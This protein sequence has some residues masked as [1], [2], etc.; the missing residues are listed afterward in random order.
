MPKP[1]LF[2]ARAALLAASV[3]FALPAASQEFRSLFDGATLE[4]W[5]KQGHGEWKV[6]DGMLVG[7]QVA[8]DTVFGHLVTD[9]AYTDFTFRYRWK[10]VKG[11]S[12]LYFRSAEGGA[13]GMIGPQVEMDGSYPG[14]IYTTN[15]A[16]WGWIVQPRSQDVAA[17]YRPGD[18]NLVIVTAKGLRVEVMYN[19]TLTAVTTD[20]RLPGSG[21]FGFQVHSRCDCEVHVDDVEVSVPVPAALGRPVR[22]TAERPGRLLFT[23]LGRAEAREAPAIPLLPRFAR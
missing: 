5:H 14:G 13:A 22:R 8:G 12:G 7:T 6:R 11:N 20:S 4:G 16:P 19:G 15:T 17:W 18:W 9:S 1:Y 23:A 21:R 3:S 2:P 10:L